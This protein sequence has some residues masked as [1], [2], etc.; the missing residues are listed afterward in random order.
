MSVAPQVAA[1]GFVA[2][3]HEHDLAA[4]AWTVDEVWFLAEMDYA[5]AVGAALPKRNT[6]LKA[7]KQCPGTRF[8]YDERV[9]RGGKT[10]KSTI[11]RF[12][13]DAAGNPT[14]MQL[15]FDLAA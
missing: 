10:V 11:Y 6:F 15:A 12:D 14:P 8:A 4:Q 2:W 7:L 5:P 3:L 9:R 13:V 1:A